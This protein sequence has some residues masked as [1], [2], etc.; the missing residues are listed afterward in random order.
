MHRRVRVLSK[1]EMHR[2]VRDFVVPIE[3]V[4]YSDQTIEEAL[5]ILHHAKIEK[6]IFYF[7]VLDK[8]GQLKG[9]VA[10]RA[11]VLNPPQIPLREVMV[12]NFAFLN[13]EQSM[14]EAM[15]E[16]EKHRLLALPVIDDQFHF[17][18]VIDVEIY[19]DET[20]KKIDGVMRR[21]IFQFIGLKI[22]EGK[23][24]TAWKG[25]RLRM[26]WLLCNVVSG[27]VCAMIANYFQIVLAKFLILAMF[28]PLVL[29]L[30]ESVSMQAMTQSLGILRSPRFLWA[31]IRRRISLEIKTVLFLSLTC[32]VGVGVLTWFW[33]H[34]WS[35]AYAIGASL[36]IAIMVSAIVGM[37]IPLT[38]RL[39]KLDPK[40]AA[41]PVILMIVDVAA[42]AIYFSLAS[43]WLL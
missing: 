41:G 32:A 18:G 5:R 8:I 23:I 11:L 14:K 17:L 22:E 28:I 21:D 43:L 27:L 16:I 12:T 3:V 35:P 29:T 7:Y 33:G 25:Y 4:L 10:T 1:E 13:A 20:I 34:G 40:L 6:E 9:V 37:L 31:I 30:C 24:G 15:H 19:F 26:P 38:L 39:C 36:L 42:T 2:P